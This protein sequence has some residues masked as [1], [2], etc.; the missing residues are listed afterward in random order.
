MRHPGIKLVV[1]A[2]GG[3]NAAVG[4]VLQAVQRI[5]GTGVGT[6]GREIALQLIPGQILQ[7]A[8]VHGKGAV[9]DVLIILGVCSALIVRIFG[10]VTAEFC[11]FVPADAPIAKGPAGI[12]LLVVIGL[13][14]KAVKAPA[15]NFH[16]RGN[17]LVLRD[18][19]HLECS[20]GIRLYHIHPGG[21]TLDIYRH[22]VRLGLVGGFKNV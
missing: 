10:P 11:R 19:G 3:K 21:H 7:I 1:A 13:L 14:V 5:Q 6:A 15:Q 17:A 2:D 8:G 20:S 22:G 16:I 9:L 12:N 18:N 4:R